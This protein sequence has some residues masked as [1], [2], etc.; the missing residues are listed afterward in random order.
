MIDSLFYFGYGPV[1]GLYLLARVLHAAGRPLPARWLLRLGALLHAV[2]LGSRV[3]SAGVIL[4]LA[5]VEA[6]FFIPWVVAELALLPQRGGET[7]C[8]NEAP[9]AW[10]A[11]LLALPALFLPHGPLPPFVK[12]ASVHAFLFF[13]CEGA[14]HA[15]FY[16]AA[17]L[18][19]RRHG[20][21]PSRAHGLAVW[22][23]VLYS[24]GQVTGSIWCDL[25][26][27]SP[28]LWSQRH[29]GSAAIWLWYAGYLHLRFLPGRGGRGR[30]AMLVAGA[31]IALGF[32]AAG[33]VTEMR[34]LRMGN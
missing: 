13:L 6:T 2:F 5:A 24:I 21:P 34:Q 16:G 33:L 15:C 12:A 10:L 17:W 9:L 32:L 19:L 20:A 26:W 30:K 27:G 4:P 3:V 1:V 18:S 8:E 31:L 22:G 11:L 7:A 25:G 28:F 29:L 23:F 14:A